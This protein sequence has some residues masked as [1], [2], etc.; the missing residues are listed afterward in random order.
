[1]RQYQ[2]EEG[3]KWV[4][5]EISLVIGGIKREEKTYL[6]KGREGV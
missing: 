1:M 6:R 5:D 4:S 2:N 3:G